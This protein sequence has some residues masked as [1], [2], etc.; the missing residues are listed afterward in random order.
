MTLNLQCKLDLLRVILIFG[1]FYIAKAQSAVLQGEVIAVHDG[2]TLT[3]K[4]GSTRTKVRLTGIDALELHQLFGVES[5]TSLR[6]LALNKEVQIETLKYYKYK[7]LIG[8]VMVDG[9]DLNLL[10]L[11]SGDAWVCLT[12][13]ASIK[14]QDLVNYMNAQSAAQFVGIG[15]W[16]NQK[17]TPP[18]VWRKF[19]FQ[20]ND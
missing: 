7:R 19:I 14:G 18:W 20:G 1:V 17:P 13:S 11:K 3:V 10:Q 5:R 8:R 9:K 6:S 4:S 12:Y 16:R 2:D 15:L